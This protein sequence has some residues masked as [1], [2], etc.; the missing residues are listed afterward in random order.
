MQE[1]L[2]L[3]GDPKRHVEV[4]RQ[5]AA[6]AGLSEIQQVPLLEELPRVVS[7]WAARRKP[8]SGVERAFPYEFSSEGVWVKRGSAV[9]WPLYIVGVIRDLSDVEPELKVRH[10]AVPMNRFMPPLS[11]TEG[12]FSALELLPAP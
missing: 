2:Q 3:A 11:L 10:A 5:A 9:G 1:T 12:K 6:E 7:E 8:E 4:I